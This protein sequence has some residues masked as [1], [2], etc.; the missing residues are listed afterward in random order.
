MTAATR[1]SQTSEAWVDVLTPSR[2]KRICNRA[3]RYKT[4]AE[5]NGVIRIHVP[6]IAHVVQLNRTHVGQADLHPEELLVQAEEDV[7]HNLQPAAQGP[8]RGGREI[9]S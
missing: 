4:A 6:H 7:L 1:F 5:V 2:G 3:D 9:R 8:G